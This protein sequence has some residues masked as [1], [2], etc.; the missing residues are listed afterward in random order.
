MKGTA[1][2]A[3]GMIMAGIVLAGAGYMLVGADVKGFNSKDNHFVE[4]SY[5]CKDEITD[6]RIRETSGAVVLQ[7][8]DTDKV[9]V[10]YMDKE[11]E[12][13]Y[14]ITESDG[15]LEIVRKEKGGF[16]FF[17][18]DFSEHIMTVTVPDSLKGSV[19]ISDAGGSI[20]LDGISAEEIEATNAS[21][22]VKLNDVS[23]EKDLTVEN[24]SGSIALTDVDAGGNASVHGVSGGIRLE[25]L[26]AGKDVK[27]KNTSGSIKVENLKADGDISL[28]NTSGSIKGTIA[29]KESDYSISAH[30]T[31]GSSN[32]QNSSQGGQALNV[33]ATT[34]SI[35]IGFTE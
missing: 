11:D 4:K 7:T 34:G 20:R 18:I 27:V 1:A 24:A 17:S 30:V 9:S 33:S 31:T 35:K 22:S 26:T 25:N 14:E 32:L 5:E 6:I 10:S 3:V 19:E 12:S 16:H 23:C 13:V 29:G 15:R 8:G 2:A 21:G 28:E